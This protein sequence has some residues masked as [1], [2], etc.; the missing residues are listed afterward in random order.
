MAH[1]TAEVNNEFVKAALDDLE[2]PSGIKEL[3]IRGYSGRQYAWWMQNKVGGG[4]QGLHYFPFLRMMKLCD[5]PNLK[6]LHDLVELPCLE[7]LGLRG[8][9]SLESISGGPFPS[10]VKLKM[11]GLPCLEE[12]WMVAER[13]MPVGEDGGGCCNFTPQLG[14][15]R[16]GNCL[17]E[18]EISDCPKLEVK[19]HLAAA[20]DLVGQ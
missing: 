19:P 7:E 12:V 3:R 11:N 4:V 16:V 5:F 17:M 1:D 14:Q 20:L 15:F 9:S 2:P 10:L 18:L 8:M 6:H 13:T